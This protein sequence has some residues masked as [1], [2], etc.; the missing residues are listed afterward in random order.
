MDANYKHIP[1]TVEHKNC[2]QG[3]KDVLKK[4]GVKWR[5]EYVKVEV[6]IVK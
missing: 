3:I 4:I 2:E 5:P 6:N 1:V